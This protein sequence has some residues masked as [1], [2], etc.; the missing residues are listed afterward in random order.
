MTTKESTGSGPPRSWSSVASLNV[1]QRNHTNTLEIRLETEDGVQCALSNEEIERLLRRLNIG[2]SDFTSVQAYPERRNVVFITLANNINLNRFT[3]NHTES[4]ILKQGIRTTTLKHASKKEV[5]VHIFGL[6]PDTKDEV[7]IRYL[8]AH[9]KVDGNQPVIYAVYPGAPGTSLLAG[10]RNGNRIYS[11]EVRKNIGSVH[12]IDGERVSI[13]YNGQR[14]TC[15]KCHQ[16]ADNCPGKAMAKNCTSQKVPLSE[17]MLSYWNSINYLPD[18]TELNDEVD[19]REQENSEKIVTADQVPKTYQQ[20][21]K[22][23]ELSARYGGVVVKGLKK[24]VGTESILPV[25]IKAGLPKN[26]S[27]EDLK[28]VEKGN[29]LTIYIY[30]LQPKRCI[31]LVNNLN[32]KTVLGSVI[33]MFAL[34]DETPEKKDK[35]ENGLVNN[36]DQMNTLLS[37]LSEQPPAP[38]TPLQ[39]TSSSNGSQKGTLYTPIPEPK[40]KFWGKNNDTEE[41][42][43]SDEDSMDDDLNKIHDNLKRKALESPDNSML[44]AFEKVLTKKQRKKL[45]RSLEKKGKDQV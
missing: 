43:S 5:N 18:S 14:R 37:E 30:D 7:V 42:D 34:V 40:A 28:R 17:Y 25:L 38:V 23:N 3:D 16:V 13:R 39:S 15:N 27:T 8:N 22:E 32:G 1:S 2:A 21:S 36:E 10:K 26:F 35:H 20:V 45:K 6:H 12:I 9:G 11:M 33:K 31:K 44:A 29:S 4:F 41:T 19:D 24:E